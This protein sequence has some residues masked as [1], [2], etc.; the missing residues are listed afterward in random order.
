MGNTN[1]KD[2]NMLRNLVI[3]CIV[4]ACLSKISH[5]EDYMPNT[6]GFYNV[7]HEIEQIKT[8]FWY[9]AKFDQPEDLGQCKLGKMHLCV[10]ATGNMQAFSPQNCT[11]SYYYN[12]NEQNLH[13]VDS[14]CNEQVAHEHS[15]NRI[16]S[17]DFDSGKNQ[18]KINFKS[19]FPLG[20]GDYVFEH[21]DSASFT[22]GNASNDAPA[23]QCPAKTIFQY[24]S[25]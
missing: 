6:S 16:T 18:V 9:S 14:D 5:C 20:G 15:D 13:Y 7:K 17:V 2:T 10:Q 19:H 4:L 21:A 1:I 11:M 25:K 23:K 12:Q 3:F 24:L 22:C 8:T